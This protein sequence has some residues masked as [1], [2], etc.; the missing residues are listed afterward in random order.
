MND[1]ASFSAFTEDAC[2]IVLNR[3]AHFPD[4]S[5]H[6]HCSPGG[7]YTKRLQGSLKNKLFKKYATQ[8]KTMTDNA[9]K[10]RDK[11]ITILSR[12]FKQ[13]VDPV[14]NEIKTVTLDPKLT[15]K[16]LQ[17]IVVDARKLIVQL[18]ISCE[19][20]YLE[21]IQTFESIVETQVKQVT[22]EKIKNLQKQQETLITGPSKQ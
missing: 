19:T 22:R 17:S 21:I 2:Q 20:E 6:K 4:F 3:L 16:S 18:Y 11:L 10:N 5:L 15:N 9:N 13:K 1:L 8:L 14:T 7:L 12:I